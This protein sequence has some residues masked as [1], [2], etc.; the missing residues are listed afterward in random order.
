M[1]QGYRFRPPPPPRP[2]RGDIFCRGS[3]RFLPPG[4][5]GN[6]A[7]ALAAISFP[8][9]GGGCERRSNPGS[10][11]RRPHSPTR[12]AV[13]LRRSGPESATGRGGTETETET[14]TEN[15]TETEPETGRSGAAAPGCAEVGPWG[16]CGAVVGPAGVGAVWGLCGT[17]TGPVWD[18]RGL[19][20]IHMGPA[21]V[22]SLL[23]ALWGPWDPCRP[24]P[25]PLSGA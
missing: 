11:H 5:S 20:R 7:R 9:P 8:R 25:P 10:Q 21:W 6:A 14:E 1:I 24:D 12:P 19:R 22:R 4:G 17:C 23:K 13:M 15:E 3:G 2:P 16:R 18:V